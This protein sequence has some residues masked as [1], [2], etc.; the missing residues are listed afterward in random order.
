MFVGPS[1][2]RFKRYHKKKVNF[3]SAEGSFFCNKFGVLG[4]QSREGGYLN[5]KQIEAVRRALR[6]GLKDKYVRIKIN[7]Y[8]QFS[9]TK[10]PVSSR[11]GKGKGK[12]AY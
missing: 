6:R 1:N 7:V 9:R 4:L 11:M 10:K 8:P 5:A 3:H 2:L 12:H